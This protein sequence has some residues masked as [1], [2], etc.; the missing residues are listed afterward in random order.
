MPMWLQNSEKTCVWENLLLGILL[1]VVVKMVH[2]KEV[3][4]A[5]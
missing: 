4:L 1:H 3:F 2:M 5:I